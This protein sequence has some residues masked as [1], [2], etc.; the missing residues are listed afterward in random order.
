MSLESATSTANKLRIKNKEKA[1]SVIELLG[2]HGF[3]QADIAY[4]IS[5]NPKLLLSNADRTLKPK[6]EF[7]EAFG[8]SRSDLPRI[9]SLDT[10]LLQGSLE[11][12]IIPALSF[13]K[14]LIRNHEDLIYSLKQSTRLVKCNLQNVTQPNINTLRAHGVPESNIARLIVMQPNSVSLKAEDFKE[15][16]ERVKEMG[17]DPTSRSFVLAVRSVTGMSKLNWERK[18]NTL[19][20]SGWFEDDV[21]MA[22][23]VQPIFMLSS[24]KKMG[25]LMEFFVSKL[26]LKPS[27]IAKCPNL[28]LVSL[29]KR[30]IPRCSVLQVLMSK[31]LIEKDV[32]VVWVLNSKKLIFENKFFIPYQDKAPEIKKAYQGE[33]PFLGLDIGSGDIN[34]DK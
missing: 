11:N 10:C 1:D 23:R 16:V 13:L 2:T 24:E 12:Q 30:I 9:V 33:I 7:L 32:N 28:F 31:G 19:K 8:I 3:T 34:V 6:L 5:R 14:G 22:F 25:I 18:V 4:L 17:F 21:L 29:E 20:R 26:G 27:D 15:A